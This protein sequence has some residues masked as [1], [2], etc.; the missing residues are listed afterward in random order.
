[1]SRL[2][3]FEGIYR[4]FLSSQMIFRGNFKKLFVNYV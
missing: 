1:M 3:I 4:N 2:V